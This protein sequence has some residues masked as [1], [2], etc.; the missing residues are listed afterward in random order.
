MY[1]RN[2]KL[3]RNIKGVKQFS[4]DNP[5]FTEPS[6]RWLIF[7]S[8]PRESSAGTIIPG[9]G[10][11]TALVRLGKRVLIDEDLFYE[12]VEEQQEKNHE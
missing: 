1:N 5:A 4:L 10:L 11:E 8:R 3:K 6:L 12:W 2:H 9:N 7:N